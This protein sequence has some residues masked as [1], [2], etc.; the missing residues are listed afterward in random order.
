MLS[1]KLFSLSTVIFLLVIITLGAN[2]GG[3]GSSDLSLIII[4]DGSSTEVTN[5][6][7]GVNPTFFNLIFSAD[8]NETICSANDVKVSCVYGENPALTPEFT[9][10][11][12]EGNSKACLVTLTDAWRYALMTCTMTYNS[13]ANTAISPKSVINESVSFTNGCALNDDYNAD[14]K[15][16][17][18]IG[19]GASFNGVPLNSWNDILGN[20]I[21]AFDPANSTLNYSISAGWLILSIAKAVTS[22][23]ADFELM[24]HIKDALGFGSNLAEGVRFGLSGTNNFNAPYIVVGVGQSGADEISCF[25]GYDGGGGFKST[26]VDCSAQ[27]N[28]LYVRLIATS[29][30]LS[31]QYWN[32]SAFVEF[33]AGAGLPSTGAELLS[34][35]GYP[36][37]T[38][39]IG[40]SFLEAGDAAS[41]AKIDSIEAVGI[42]VSNQY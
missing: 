21:L 23:D 11:V 26:S 1:R 4:T 22:I 15:S 5:N 2:C 35:L 27:K 3:G 33:P 28:D 36:G 38:V 13:V 32:G 8:V 31:F 42:T 39:Y 9:V 29:A 40:P 14:S 6:S 37:S 19:A 16:C 17:Y 25:V 20:N 30:S 34:A 24:I 12:S 10:A 18:E 41:S 7:T